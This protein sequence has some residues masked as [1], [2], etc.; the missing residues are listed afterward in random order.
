MRRLCLLALAALLPS[1]AG[2]APAQHP[3]PGHRDFAVPGGAEA[4]V[5]DGRLDD[6]TWRNALVLSL[7]WETSPGENTPAPVGTECLL[8]HD[9]ERLYVA[10][11]A[12]DPDTTAI[13]ARLADR[14]DAYDD[15]L[16]G[17]LLD[18]FDGERRGYQFLVSAAGV[19]MDARRDEV[20][21]EP[22]DDSWDAIWH[23]AVRRTAAGYDV[24][25]AV[26]FRALRFPP[27]RL[28]VTW[29]FL[30]LR[31][32]PRNVQRRFAALPLDRG[33]SCALCQ[34]LKVTGF[35][36]VESGRN[37]KIAPTWTA[38]RTDRREP[39][40]DAAL[41]DGEIMAEPGLDLRWGPSSQSSL[42]LS[43]NP[44]FSQV[45]A[46]E[47][48]LELNTRYALFYREKRPFFLEGADI[49]RTPLQ[50]VYTRT[51]VDPD[52]GLKWTGQDGRTATGVIVARD[53]SP[54]RLLASNQGS[55]V[56]A[57]DRELS[58]AVLRLR[59]DVGGG[60]TVG[61]LATG[62]AGRGDEHDSGLVGTDGLWRPSR[63]DKLSWQ[64]LQSGADEGGGAAALARWNH[65][66]RDWSLLAGFQ[67]LDEKFRAD[68]GFIPRVDLR[69][70]DLGA[71]RT[72]WNSP[73]HW[74][75]QLGAGV[76]WTYAE[77]QAG[78][79]ADRFLRAE[80]FWMGPMQGR[81]WGA[82]ENGR[83]YFA[84]RDFTTTSWQAKLGARPA[85]ALE[86]WLAG[87][88]GEAIDY[89]NARPGDSF[90]LGPGLGYTP[91]RNLALRLDATWENFDAAGDDL[92]TALLLAVQVRYHFSSRAFARAI[93]H[94][95]RYDL[96]P[97]NYLFP[98]PD[99]DEGLF[100]QLL[101]SYKVNPQ[102]M[103][104]VGT[105]DEAAGTDAY[106]LT[107]RSRT[108]FLKLGYAWLP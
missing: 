38:T 48:Q 77:T 72:W 25:I 89:D 76:Q 84:G 27:S 50:A 57:V 35:A 32:R 88:G 83:Q 78:R 42:N 21:D 90:G 97:D 73:E 11:R 9:A 34:T 17:F 15:D 79:L 99:V 55:R 5:L 29:G 94:Y 71:W 70:Y 46:D 85:G 28:P 33:N 96:E 23:S 36:G 26:P 51:I 107:R 7:D 59:R 66:G 102:T 60:S 106:E 6:A 74:Y 61:L 101:F 58:S 39:F 44:D 43:L 68:A 37:L 65:D 41:G 13:V 87:W 22:E 98:V 1:L 8:T 4:P 95:E 49:F 63:A 100:S 82:V 47:L 18:P 91:S 67:S 3:D 19:Q 24:E 104:F 45:E 10:F 12:L 31:D 2:A 69:Q 103:V 108:F 80:G 52:W 30:P 81:F 75:N 105:T 40:P 16:V 54:N 20:G 53:A 56:M 92:Y 93:V 62:R 14:D 64:F 86:L